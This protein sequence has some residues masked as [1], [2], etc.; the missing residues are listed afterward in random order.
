MINQSFLSC[1]PIYFKRTLDEDAPSIFKHFDPVERRK[2]WSCAPERS[3]ITACPMRQLKAIDS[4]QRCNGELRLT[5]RWVIEN[6]RGRK[7]S[8]GDRDDVAVIRLA[9]MERCT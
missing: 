8:V 7:P 6:V 1:F 4:S 5:R 3:G 2:C 9:R